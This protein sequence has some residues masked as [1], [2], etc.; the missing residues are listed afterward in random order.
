MSP[1]LKNT[2]ENYK[3]VYKLLLSNGPMTTLQ[4]AKKLFGG[5]A[6]EATPLLDTMNG[7][8]VKPI[9]IDGLRHWAATAALT[10]LD[11]SI[12]RIIMAQRWLNAE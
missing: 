1:D 3:A 2:R 9:T 11:S 5:N 8:L 6:W 4:I 7:M 12:S 10:D